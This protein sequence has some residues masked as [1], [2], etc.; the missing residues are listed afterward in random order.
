MEKEAMQERSTEQIAHK[1]RIIDLQEEV[2]G[3]I[4]LLE[5]VANRAKKFGPEGREIAN[6]CER[7]ASQAR[8]LG[9]G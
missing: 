2:S 3:L 8:K 7:R 1:A 6:D 5:Q 9:G 4:Q